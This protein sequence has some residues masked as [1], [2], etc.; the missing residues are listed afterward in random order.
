MK[1]NKVCRTTVFRK[2]RVL[3]LHW[4]VYHCILCP[5]VSDHV[6]TIVSGELFLKMI[7]ILCA[8]A[9]SVYQALSPPLKVSLGSRLGLKCKSAIVT[10]RSSIFFAAPSSHTTKFRLSSTTWYI[11]SKN[12]VQ[13]VRHVGYL[14]VPEISSQ[15]EMPPTL[16][17][18]YYHFSNRSN[19]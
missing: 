9:D 7:R 12:L 5:Y 13:T 14:H 19:M 3:Q 1:V 18:C 17:T 2:Y 6:V 16:L 11:V 4:L 8:C 10:G 15:T